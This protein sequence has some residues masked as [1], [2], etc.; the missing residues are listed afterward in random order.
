MLSDSRDLAPDQL[1]AAALESPLDDAEKRLLGR[2]SLKI[3]SSEGMYRPGWSISYLAAG[4]S[5]SRGIHASLDAAGKVISG[6]AVL[7]FP[8]GYGRV[9]RFLKEV[10]P[11]SRIVGADIEAD[12]VE[13]CQRAF[14][15]QGYLSNPASHFGSLSLPWKFDLIWCGSLITHLDQP[16]AVALL[17]FFCRHLTEGGVCVFTTHGRRIADMMTRKEIT[18]DLTEQGRL[19]VL[20]DYQQQGYGFADYSG[21]ASDGGSSKGYG[22]SVSSQSRVV[23]MA[24]GVGPWEDVYYRESGWHTIQDVHAFMLRSP[25]ISPG[26]ERHE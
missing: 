11:D 14:S 19:K 26:Q 7:D 20:Q 16:A 10:F 5:A 25:D 18:F 12:A 8:C 4:L 22:I 6:G 9:L 2:I 13:F 3:S 23:E 21:A 24:R 15:V 17:E 1:R